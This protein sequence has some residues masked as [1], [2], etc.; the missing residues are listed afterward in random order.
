[1]LQKRHS[2]TFSEDDRIQAEQKIKNVEDEDDDEFDVVNDPSLLSRD[3]KD[4]KVRANR[5]SYP[6]AAS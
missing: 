6:Q 1:M 5:Y 3:P 2:R 4:W